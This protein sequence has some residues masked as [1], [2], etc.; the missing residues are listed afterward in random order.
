MGRWFAGLPWE[1]LQPLPVGW[2]E[3]TAKP[4]TGRTQGKPIIGRPGERWVSPLA[5][6]ILRGLAGAALRQAQDGLQPRVLADSLVKSQRA[7]GCS[8]SHGSPANP[9][10]IHA[11]ITSWFTAG[12]HPVP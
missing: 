2:V 3:P 8:R 10:P 6:P 7:S 4:I 9:L 11:T 1:R 5:L 12:C